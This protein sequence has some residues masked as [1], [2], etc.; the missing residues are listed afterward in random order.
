[1]T[2]LTDTT[3]SSTLATDKDKHLRELGQ[4]VEG[5]AFQWRD[6]LIEKAGGTRSAASA[7]GMV[8]FILELDRLMTMG[9]PAYGRWASARRLQRGG[10]K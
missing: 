3:L 1:M 9:Q 8:E 5:V 7:R 2:S 4:T 10:R 6:R